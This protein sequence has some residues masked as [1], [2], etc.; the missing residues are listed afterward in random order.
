MNGKI[1][2]EKFE[3]NEARVESSEGISSMEGKRKKVAEPKGSTASV[4]KEKKKKGERERK[5]G[6][7]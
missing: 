3:G 2:I 6:S 1:W 4:E 5:L 7:E